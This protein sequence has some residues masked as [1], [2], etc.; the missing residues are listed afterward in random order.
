[1]RFQP[2]EHSYGDYGWS[3]SYP[4]S[5]L[6][7]SATASRKGLSNQPTSSAHKANLSRLSDFLGDLPFKLTVTSAYRSPEVNAA[8]GG[9]S[10]SQHPN[11]LAVDFV[12]EGGVS[13][14]DVAAWFYENRARFPELDQVIWYTDTT[15]IHIGICPSGAS[16]CPRWEARGEF[17]QATKEGGVYIPW[18]PTA[19]ETAKMA[20]L[21]AYHRPLQTAGAVWATV[22][23]TVGL[24]LTALYWINRGVKRQRSRKRAAGGLG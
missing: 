6:T 11:G 17:L 18:A 19:A 21:Y 20:A 10:S 12:P 1:M 15:H 2:S 8:V 4:L 22:V 23:V 24:S 3:S 16:N 13:N 9:S 7:V 5:K 14:K